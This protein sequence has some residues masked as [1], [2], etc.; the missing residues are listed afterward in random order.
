METMVD[1]MGH[2]QSADILSVNNFYPSWFVQSSQSAN[3]GLLPKIMFF[4]KIL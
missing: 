3:Y 2:D 4:A 1:F